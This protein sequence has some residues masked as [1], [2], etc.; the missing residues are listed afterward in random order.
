V[1]AGWRAALLPTLSRGRGRGLWKSLHGVVGFWVSLFLVAFLI[2]GL[3]W[4][5]I[6]G[7][8]M[9]QAWSQFPAEKWDNVPLSDATHASMDHDRREVPW[10]LE[11][12]PMPASG[13]DAGA[14]PSPAL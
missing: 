5:G 12:T 9:V 10:V 7:G 1:G 4:A 11:Q 2:S 6:W 3:A 14:T 8:K 13:S